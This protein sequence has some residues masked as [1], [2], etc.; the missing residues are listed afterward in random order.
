M[1]TRRA[2]TIVELMVSI[3]V[4]MITYAAMT[5]SAQSAKQTAEHEAGRLAAYIFRMIQKA[6]RMHNGFKMNT[7]PGHV[8]INWNSG[9]EDVSFKA[10]TGC[11][12]TN[13]FPSNRTYNASNRR[14]TSGG[15]ITV[16]DSQGGVH[17]VFIAGITEGRIR[18]SPTDNPSSNEEP[19]S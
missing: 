3:A 2:F 18:L 4:M 15:K 16:T 14:F 1:K 6:D 12:Y 5:V 8:Y 7:A 11:R 10:T 19:S 13:N 17:Y 9:P